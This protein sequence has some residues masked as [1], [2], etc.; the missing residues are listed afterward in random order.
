M[1]RVTYIFNVW[2]FQEVNEAYHIEHKNAST[3]LIKL[4]SRVW[5]PTFFCISG[6]LPVNAHAETYILNL[7]YIINSFSGFLPVNAHPLDNT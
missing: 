4:F 1:S 6:I 5:T 2:P 3:F 7:N